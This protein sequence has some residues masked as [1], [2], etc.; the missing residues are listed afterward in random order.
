VY[1]AKVYQ[2]SQLALKGTV[3]AVCFY[4]ALSG[5]HPP[6]Q[7]QNSPQLV[8]PVLTAEDAVQDTRIAEMNKHLEVADANNTRVWAE[9][10]KN[11]AD[12]AGMQG[13]E[14]GIGAFLALLS[15]TGIVLQVRSKKAS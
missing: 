5:T 13:E 3:F 4:L 2:Y 11:A 7:A 14:R 15:G 8:L 6:A 10:Q 1:R 12:I 9:T